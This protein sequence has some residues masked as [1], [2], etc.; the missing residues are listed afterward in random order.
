MP[1]LEPRTLG[2]LVAVAVPSLAAAT[3]IVWLLEDQLGVPN[4]SAVYLLA[5]VATAIGSGTVGAIASAIAGIVLY[6]F[7]FTQPLH[8]LVISD[9]DEWLNLV[10][11]LFVALVV[12]QLTA[13]QR[14][15]AE[16]AKARERE[17]VELFRV[18]RALATRRS[19]PAVLPEIA[20]ILEG[21]IGMERVWI[22]LG[23]DDAT[24]RLAAESR[25]DL[26]GG[27][28]GGLRRP[29]TSIP[30]QVL[31]RTP[32]DDPAQ[33]VRVHPPLAGRTR[34]ARESLL[35]FRVRIEFGET[36]L[37]SVW[38]ELSSHQPA[39]DRTATRLLAAAADQVGQA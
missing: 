17:A 15:R 3:G 30:H 38:G 22:S 19:T 12:G 35:T 21:A 27:S 29:P 4:A 28:D 11:L 37:G 20:Q 24:E 18:S 34:T 6:D 5:V 39:P 2:R 13:L 9:P 23:R 31:R 36:Q 8:T 16:V 14:A 1:P 7:L 26:R 10:L 32:G 33:W 25:A